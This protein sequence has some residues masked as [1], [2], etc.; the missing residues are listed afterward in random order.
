MT[1][2]R[3]DSNPSLPFQKLKLDDQLLKKHK[4][5]IDSFQE[6]LMTVKWVHV[7][8]TL[9]VLPPTFI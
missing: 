3:F 6:Y 7:L 8:L 2:G 9:Q 1:W 4:L 5:S